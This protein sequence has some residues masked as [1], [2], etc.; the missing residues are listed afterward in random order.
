M[1][2]VV[3]VP[4]KKNRLKDWDKVA[5]VNL[6]GGGSY[7]GSLGFHVVTVFVVQPDAEVD[8]LWRCNMQ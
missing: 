6:L 4:E 7:N 2:E 8:E 5:T 1:S 3:D